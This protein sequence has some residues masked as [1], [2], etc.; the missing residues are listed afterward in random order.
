MLACVMHTITDHTLFQPG[1]TVVVAVSGGVDSM[2]L[3]DLLARLPELRLNL[4]VA[5]LNHCLRGEESDGDEA[6][7]REAAARYGLPF[8]SRRVDVALLKV[9]EGLSLEDAGRVARYAFLAETADSLK[10]RVVALAH[11]ADDQAETVLLRLLRGSAA[12]GLCAMQPKSADGRYVRPLLF[13]SRQEIERY[14]REQ[15][16]RFRHD[17]SNDDQRFLR[18]RI[19]HELLP[20][21]AGYNPAI[22]ERLAA[23]AA[24]LAEDEAVLEQATLR[25]F[26]AC[27]V[28]GECPATLDLDRVRGELRGL[29]LRLYRYAIRETKGDLARISSRHLEDIDRLVFAERPQARLN[30]P[31]GLRV[32]RVYDR[33]SFRLTGGEDV[34][35]PYELIVPGAGD[36]PLP[37]GGRLVVSAAGLPMQAATASPLAARIDLEKAPFPWRV[38][39]FG[40]GDR[41]VPAGMTGRKKVKKLFMEERIPLEMRARIPLVFSRDNLIWVGGLRKSSAACADATVRVCVNAEIL[42][43]TPLTA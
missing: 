42:D 14:A 39:T 30:L 16:I 5:H 29:R 3:L 43:F 37:G 25:A 35:L 7:A 33:L 15:V 8:V 24:A 21:L 9:R 23:T 28:K 32:S 41:L 6:F 40:A 27:G 36:Y 17:A 18:N 2:V 31:A 34:F 4:V 10:A 26:D 19:R 38:R 22:A 20:A 13:T 1:D 11:H 12:P